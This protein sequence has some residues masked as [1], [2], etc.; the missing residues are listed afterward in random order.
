MGWTMTSSTQLAHGEAP[1]SRPAKKRGNRAPAFLLTP[2]GIVIIALVVIPLGFMIFTSFTDFSQRTLFT[3]EFD[4]VGLKQYQ[5][6]LTDPAFYA[7]LLRTFGF[8]AALVAGSVLAGMGVAQLM[9]K[10][11]G[12]MRYLV[13]FVLIFAWAMPNVASS[14]VW[15]WLFQPGY[16]V[17]NWLLAQLHVFGDMTNTSWIDNTWLAFLEIWLLVVW[18]AV[19]YIAITLYAATTQVDQSCIEAAQLDG[20]SKLRCYWQIVVPLISPSIMVITMLSIIWDFNVFNQIWLI[21]Q[22][23]PQDTTATIGIFTYKKAFVSFEIG[24]GSAASVLVT[25]VLLALTSVYIRYLL[26]SGEDL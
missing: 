20:C 17:I 19:P 5:S 25:I 15:K 2:A 13:I 4:F 3:G 22:G 23:G 9:T 21:S 8:T 24:T 6:V 16:G 14:V 1:A 26:K 7:A 10:L 11:G 12:V 18:Q